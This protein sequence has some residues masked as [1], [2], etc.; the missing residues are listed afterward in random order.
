[1][2][3]SGP[4]R[5]ARAG[6]WHLA[7]LGLGLALFGFLVYQVGPGAIFEAFH[8]LGWLTPLVV[9]PYLAVYFVDSLGWGTAL[10]CCLTDSGSDRPPLPRLGTLFAIRAA[11]EAVNAITPTAYLGGEPVKAWLLKR[12]GI[13]LVP[14]FASVLISKT[15][16]VLTQGIFVLLGLL[17]ALHRSRPALSLPLLAF[18]GLLLGGGLAVLLIGAQRRGLFGLLLKLSRRWSGREALLVSWEAD[19]R[20]LD[21]TLRQFYDGRGRDFLVCSGLHLLGWLLGCFEVYGA[22][23]MLGSPVA[24][25]VALSLEALSGVA[26]LAAAIVP[27]SLGVQEGGQVVLFVAFSLGAP[28]GMTFSLLRRGRELLWVGFGLAVLARRQG[29]A[30]IRQE[31]RAV[32]S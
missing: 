24:F 10:S 6:L 4:S 15:A 26:K 9:A 25:P 1:M 32:G 30:W 12:D 19:I 27:G 3:P 8:R 31:E 16:L 11:G 17:V 7:W 2:I 14:G 23:W 28:L 22:L 5:K 18:G 13:P 20:S 21:Q 29:W